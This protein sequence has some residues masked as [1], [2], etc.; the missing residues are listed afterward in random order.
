MPNRWVDH[1]KSF[2]AQN[3]LS[4]AC[5]LSTPDC[6]E[7]YRAKYGVTKKLTK[8][9]NIEK[10]G[11]EDKDAPNIQLIIKEKRKPKRG[12]KQFNIEE[13]VAPKE[14]APAKAKTQ[15]QKITIDKK[16]YYLDPR[17]NVLYESVDNYKKGIK[18][19]IW[20]A[21]TKT[22]QKNQSKKIERNMMEAEDIRSK[23]VATQEKKKKVLASLPKPKAEPEPEPAP[24]KVTVKRFTHKGV[25]Y[26]KAVDTNIL[27]DSKTKEE[28]G[29]WDPVTETIDYEEDSEDDE[30]DED[31]EYNIVK[32][33]LMELDRK[34][35][36]Y[37]NDT[38][39]F[40]FIK[41]YI[42]NPKKEGKTKKKIVETAYKRFQEYPNTNYDILH[43]VVMKPLFLK[44]KKIVETAKQIKEMKFRQ[45]TLDLPDDMKREILGFLPS[46]TKDD[47]ESLED[48]YQNYLDF[49]SQLLYSLEY[50]IDEHNIKI[51]KK[52]KKELDTIGDR[53][54]GVKQKV[55][56]IL[57]KNG[58]D[59]DED[60][61]YY[62][63]SGISDYDLRKVGLSYDDGKLKSFDKKEL[64]EY[65]DSLDNSIDG[66][67]KE[68][69]KIGDLKPPS[70]PIK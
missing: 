29:V 4:Y 26:F 62:E 54:Y 22:I 55:I 52:L 69:K 8:K 31:E 56:D 49:N 60:N 66:W 27:Y 51:S 19:G 32:K 43:S 58:I 7:T 42:I 11:A 33:I 48:L 20:N 68:I 36:R 61:L 41:D 35:G 70:K 25:E 6:K 5:A 15:F 46:F 16:K 23:M 14:P 37:G 13:N 40:G 59:T 18:V 64:D 30:D 44:L 28:I 34:E 45:L 24:K 3:N 2:A 53:L 12:P 50:V 63:L 57:E 39:P 17:D 38:D 21:K 67:E 1:V 10:M 9:Q 47:K 65:L